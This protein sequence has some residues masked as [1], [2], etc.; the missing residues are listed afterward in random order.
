ME[1]RVACVRSR[2]DGHPSRRL[3]RERTELG[4]PSH[5]TFRCS[6]AAS[7][8]QATQPAALF[9]LA[10]LGLR[11]RQPCGLVVP[12]VQFTPDSC[13]R[14]VWE[15][16]PLRVQARLLASPIRGMLRQREQAGDQS[17]LKGGGGG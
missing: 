11:F 3:P 17:A 7:D 5:R 8:F 2:A 15:A 13:S 14:V 9:S 16:W 4:S 12:S 6:A 10:S 1:Q